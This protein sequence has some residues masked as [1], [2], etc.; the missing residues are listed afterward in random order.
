MRIQAIFS[1]IGFMI[2]LCGFMMLPPALIDWFNGE[3]SVSLSFLVTAGITVGAGTIILIATDQQQIP[4]RT[5]EMFLTT[6][7]IWILYSFFCALPYF[8]SPTP[9]TF[10]ES[11][12]ESVS[13]LTATGATNFV[14]LDALSHGILL[15]RSLTQ[16]MGG[17]GILVLA[18]M[19]LPTL[20]IGGMQLF[21]I[22]TSGESNRDAPTMSQNVSGILIYFLFMTFI[23][24]V[25][26]YIAGMD[27]FDAI[28]HAMTTTATGGFSTHSQSI[29]Y[30][31]NPVIEWILIVFM[32][33]GGLP[34]MLGIYLKQ[35]HFDHIR[36]NE[37]IKLYCTV[38]LSLAFIL[39][40]IRWFNTSFDNIKL[41]EIL[42]T[43]TF[44]VISI[45]TSTGFT[46]DNYQLWGHYAI[47]FFMTIMLLGA[48]TGSTSGGIKMFRFSILFKVIRSRMQTT[49][50]PHGVFVPRYGDTPVS[51]DVIVSVLVFMGLYALSLIIGSAALSLCNLDFMTSFSGT[52]SALSNIGPALGDIIGPDKNFALLPQT[53]KWILSFLMILGRLEFVAVLILFFPFFWKKNV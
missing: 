28:N 40:S 52:I 49:A 11:I 3:Q 1:I 19:V 4:L 25:C 30:F 51:D 48:C 9:I 36:S 12:F 45:M 29:A 24:A 26:L 43:T 47:A 46:V 18:I 15:W 2:V 53:A 22:E 8:L 14:N 32:F 13:G 6:T 10:T 35:R 23:C 34:L 44:D 31:Q 41:E 38:F 33:I 17:V 42:R 39:S 21:N 16:W 37:Q 20:H 5:K 7:L 27:I 50:R